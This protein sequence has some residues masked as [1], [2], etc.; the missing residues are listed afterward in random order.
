MSEFGDL[1]EGNLPGSSVHGI[2]QARVP[3]WVA[4]NRHHINHVN[5][6]SIIT[7]EQKTA[8]SER[9][10]KASLHYCS[11]IPAKET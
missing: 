11:A 2:L 4:I 3:E 8:S 5:K 10:N 6:V 9:M 7:M 1:M